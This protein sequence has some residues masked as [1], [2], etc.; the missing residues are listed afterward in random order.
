MM[1]YLVFFFSG[2][3]ANIFSLQKLRAR[4]TKQGIYLWGF[5]LHSR[6]YFPL[7][8]LRVQTAPAFQLM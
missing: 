6:K 1:I 2:A 5:F 4:T 8:S 7:K 3:L